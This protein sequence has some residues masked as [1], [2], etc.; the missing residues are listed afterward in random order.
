M[1]GFRIFIFYLTFFFTVLLSSWTY[2][3]PVAPVVHTLS[4]H[5]GFNFEARQWG[6]E[7]LRGWETIDG[8][9]IVFDDDLQSWT[10]AVHGSDGSLISS[11]RV[12]GR[13]YP[14]SDVQKSI[15]PIGQARLASALK[16]LSRETSAEAP[17]RTV[18]STGT[19]NIPIILI[20]FSDTTTTFTAEDFNTLLFGTDNY[21]MKDYYE[22]VSYGAFSISAGPSGTVGWYQ[23]SH[24]HDYYGANV[25]SDGDDAWPGDLVYEAVAAADAA[26]FN[27]A[28]YDQDNDCYVDVVAI[29]HQGSGE[30][31]SGRATDIWSHRWTLNGANYYGRSHYGAYTTNATC[32]A[33]PSKKVSDR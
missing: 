1:P 14:P 7:R 13:D 30:E 23:A 24:T 27:F 19:A 4:Q 10:Y 16:L 6:D 8:Y 28:A 18:S 5:D 22:E 31:A 9:S 32:T 25:S 29:V 21:S 33:D 11:S 12:I 20:N 2:A 3:V 26:G 17:Q 15:R